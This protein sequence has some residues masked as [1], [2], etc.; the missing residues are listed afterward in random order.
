VGE[1]SCIC[2]LQRTAKRQKPEDFSRLEDEALHEALQVALP[3]A[4]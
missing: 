3:L 4:V 2:P 1:L